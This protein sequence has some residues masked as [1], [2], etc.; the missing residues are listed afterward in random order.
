MQD[1]D[2]DKYRGDQPPRRDYSAASKPCKAEILKDRRSAVGGR[3]DRGL[4]GGAIEV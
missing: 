4:D 2:K 1:K 3:L